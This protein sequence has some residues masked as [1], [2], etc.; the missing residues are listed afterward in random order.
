MADKHLGDFSCPATHLLSGSEKLPQHHFANGTS[1]EVLYYYAH[2]FLHSLVALLCTLPPEAF[3][4]SLA[5]VVQLLNPEALLMS[6]PLLG[7]IFR[8]NCVLTSSA[9]LFLCFG[10]A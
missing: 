8:M 10:N 2:R 1:G 6:V 3:W 9:F 5:C 7:T 4:L